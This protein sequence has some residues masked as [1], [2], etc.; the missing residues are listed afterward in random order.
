VTAERGSLIAAPKGEPSTLFLE[1]GVRLETREPGAAGGRST[2]GA[3]KFGNFQ[4]P[5]DLV[6]Q[7]AFRSRGEDEREL[8]L[9]EIWQYRE[10][11]PPGVTTNE[12]LAEFHDRL[13]RSLSVLFLPF[14]AVPFAIGPRRSGQ[15]YGVAVGLLILVA[16]NQTLNIG[17]A[18]ASRGEVS[19][20]IGQWLP[21]AIL[22]LGSG[23][24]FYRSAF[25]VPRGGRG[26][27]SPMRALESLMQLL[28]PRA[29]LPRRQHPE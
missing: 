22:A 28:R 7:E 6:G 26:L 1:D 3:L 14:L 15:A 9:W 25:T 11:P 13:V 18:L 29:R 16:Y 4:I 23:A 27:F 12:M 2:S 8:T 5:I 24:L 19:S 20:L 10:S 21:F 17:E